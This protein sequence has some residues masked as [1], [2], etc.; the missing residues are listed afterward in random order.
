MRKKITFFGKHLMKYTRVKN[1]TINDSL[2][3]R[4]R[5][6]LL[7][8][9]SFGESVETSKNPTPKKGRK[10]MFLHIL[11]GFL[12]PNK[13]T[14][15]NRIAC[16]KQNG[17][18]QIENPNRI[19]HLKLKLTEISRRIFRLLSARFSAGRSAEGIIRLHHRLVCFHSHIVNSC[20]STGVELSFTNRASQANKKQKTI[21]R[22]Q[23][24]PVDG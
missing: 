4:L 1:W 17:R 2:V 20:K 7:I 6:Y 14:E 24:N 8:F 21:C 3:V 12:Y 19:F 13:E 10:L 11:N 9:R 16:D 5:I 18:I 15:P 22:F 23:L